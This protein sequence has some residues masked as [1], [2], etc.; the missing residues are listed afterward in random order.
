MAAYNNESILIL[1]GGI[2]QIPAIKKAKKM[3]YKVFIADV[4]PSAPGIRFADRFCE[5]DLKNH[6]GIADEAVRLRKEENLKA[7]FTAG[8]DFSATVAYAATAAGLPGIE[9]STAMSASNKILMRRA[10]NDAGV[11]SPG[12]YPVKTAEEAFEACM[13]LDF[14]VVIKPV[15]SMGA[16]GVIKIERIE[17][18]DSISAAVASAVSA[19]SSG[20]AIIEEFIDG[21]EFSLDA[22]VYNG[23]IT[24]C[25]FADRHIYFP[26]YFIEMGHTMPTAVSD[27]I[28]LEV[29]DV[30]RQGVRAI[31]IT[32]GAAK[33]DMKYSRKKGA[34]VGEI[35][36]RLSGGFMSGWTYPYHSG[37]D[38]TSAAIRI[39][40]GGSPGSLR[41]LKNF[42]SAERAALSIPGIVTA[43]EGVEEAEQ[44]EYIKDVFISVQ[45]GSSV[46][47]P[48]NNVQKCA[49][50]ISAA[51]D[52]DLAAA[53]AE[54]AVR[55]LF[56]RL[57]PG[58]EDT[59]DFIEKRTY[60]WVPDAFV[61]NNKKNIE[62]LERL[63]DNKAG[64]ILPELEKEA[65]VEWHGE[66]LKN[67][68]RRVMRM[69]KAEPDEL[70]GAFWKALLRGGIQ[71]GVWYIETSRMRKESDN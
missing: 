65:A 39:A 12:F 64:K 17:Q 43:V 61:L 58:N 5:I 35:A 62:A 67:A 16:R 44:V 1:G 42:V 18:R 21:P 68:V 4:N 30:F 32:E 50:C 25:G 49:N 3:G 51:D 45:K 14:P 52:R 59:A 29:E 69:I 20:E 47:F 38:L 63:A 6:R 2:M 40:A 10:F 19:S 60:G 66:G 53:S 23:K 28:R 70:T 33:G 13:N 8:T 54:D 46:V 37:V 41:P 15:D 56:F 26:P 9:Y 22:L 36:A 48:V 34:M 11:P 55:K 7:V 71:G 27:E 57:E 24:V 31:G